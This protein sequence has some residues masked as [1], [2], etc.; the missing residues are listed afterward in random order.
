MTSMPLQP[1]H[2]LHTSTSALKMDEY[3]LYFHFLGRI[4]TQEQFLR[5][6]IFQREETSPK[7][8]LPPS[9][10]W[11][12]IVAVDPSINPEEH[13]DLIDP[14]KE[15]KGEALLTEEMKSKLLENLVEQEFRQAK[16]I[17][18]A[19]VEAPTKEPWVTKTLMR[20]IINMTQHF[21]KLIVIPK[22]VKETRV[23]AQC[24]KEL[25]TDQFV[26]NIAVLPHHHLEANILDRA[27]SSNE[28]FAMP[29]IAEWWLGDSIPSFMDL[30]ILTWNCR[31]AANPEFRRAFLELKR[32]HNPII[33][34]ILET[35]VSGEPANRLCDQLGFGGKHIV[36]ANGFS[37]GIW[38]IWDPTAV[39]VDIIPHGNQ[40]I[41]AV[42]QVLNSNSFNFS[43]LISGIYAS[44][45]LIKRMDLWDELVTVSNNFHGP[46]TVMGDF[47]EVI[48]DHEK[49]GG[50][51]ISP[52]RVKL[53]TDCMNACKLFDIGFVGP[54]FTWTNNWKDGGFI[55]QRLDRV[56]AN[57]EWRVKFPEAFL[58]HLARTHSDHNPILLNLSHANFS[59]S[60]R[61]FRFETA[62]LLHPE[63][64]PFIE[65][66]WNNSNDSVSKKI[67]KFQEAVKIWNKEVFGNVFKKKR[68]IEARLRGIQNK[69]ANSFNPFLFNLQKELT[70]EYQL[71]LKQEEEIWKIKARVDWVVDGDRNTR[72]FHTTTI[73]RIRK[74][75]ILSLKDNMGNWNSCPQWIK[76]SIFNYFSDIFSTA[77][78]S[79][80]LPTYLN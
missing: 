66:V 35:R 75:K 47:N 7:P 52:M 80:S 45:K 62:W 18:N 54:R 74:N 61:P 50:N 77:H 12:R 25:G 15:T 72:F 39:K 23:I 10:A 69:L 79:S 38:M 11:S 6:L 32:I 3:R 24:Y 73:N 41:H 29:K 30:K 51:R 68:Q 8:S 16:L 43:W 46:W 42:C 76:S 9:L 49:L 5:D 34:F 28:V 26:Y 78:E 31:G 44:T 19:E 20:L 60:S 40:A 56:W 53:Y 33:C 59:S 65:K 71:L 21:S 55:M 57:D 63:F 36:N 1:Q 48:H 70:S 64:L 22:E 27:P 2:P 14:N 13:M 67:D 4:V 17:V 37:G 58:S